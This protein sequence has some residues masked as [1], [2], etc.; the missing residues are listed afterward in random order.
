MHCIS[1]SGIVLA[2]NDDWPLKWAN[3]PY[4][5]QTSRKRLR[6]K[7]TPDLHL[8]YSKTRGLVGLKKQKDSVSKNELYISYKKA[9]TAP[10]ILN[11][12]YI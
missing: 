7:Y 10:K 8:T 12:E 1:K 2:Q 11:I 5:I 9:L 3:G 6:A 4:P